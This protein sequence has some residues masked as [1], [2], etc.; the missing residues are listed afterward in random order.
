RSSIHSLWHIAKSG[1]SPLWDRAASRPRI[2][3]RTCPEPSAA[4]PAVSAV[5]PVVSRAASEAPDS[6]VPAPE[7]SDRLPYGVLLLSV[8]FTLLLFLPHRVS[9]EAGALALWLPSASG[10]TRTARLLRFRSRTFPRYRDRPLCTPANS[11]SQ[12][13]C[14]SDSSAGSS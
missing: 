14:L 4:R 10:S 13:D 6:G 1:R 9:R 11:R 5:P 7:A 3:I 8:A 12:R 2:S